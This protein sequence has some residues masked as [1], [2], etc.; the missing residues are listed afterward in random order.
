MNKSSNMSSVENA[1]MILESFTIDQSEKRVTQL[2]NELGIGKSSVSRLLKTLQSRGYVKKDAETQKYSLGTKI[3]TLYSSLMS[4]MEV[5]KEAHPILEELAKETKESVQLAELEGSNV[6]YMEQIKSSFPIQIF[7]HI[8]RINPIHCTSSGKLL[9]A[10][11]DIE[12]IENILNGELKTYTTSTITDKLTLKKELLEIRNLGYCYIQN[13]FIDGIVSIAAP[14][15]DYNKNVIAA[16]SLV[17]PIQRINGSKS[18]MYINK[19]VAA[20]KEISIK[21]GY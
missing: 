18:K 5:V 6:I 1:L 19:V 2:S 15:R 14:I 10:Y 4:E 21:M 17:G 11:Q 12:T 16:V 3:L 8:G 20:A 9:L 13:E 7:A